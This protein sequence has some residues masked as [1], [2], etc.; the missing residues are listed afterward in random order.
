M[1]NV[2]KEESITVD[3]KTPK[4]F[5]ALIVNVNTTLSWG[6]QGASTQ[7]TLVEDPNNKDEDGKPAP[8][9]INIPPM[10]TPI[11]FPN[12]LTEL[13]P[14]P[15]YD[16]DENSN[17]PIVIEQF[18]LD[19]NDKKIEQTFGPFTPDK[20]LASGFLQ[21]A[22]YS[23]S[24]SGRTY[25][26]VIQS[27]ATVL[28]GVQ[29]VLNEFNGTGLGATLT[30]EVVNLMNVFGHYENLLVGGHYPF[31]ENW[32]N[33]V[34]RGGFG[35]SEV[36]DSGFP[37]LFTRPNGHTVNLFDTIVAM[38]HDPYYSAFGNPIRH[39]N[40]AYELDL[41][42]LKDAIDLKK[43]WYYRISGDVRDLG[44][45]ISE[46]CEI[47]QADWMVELRLPNA[48]SI[49]GNLRLYLRLI[50][51]TFPATPGVNVLVPSKVL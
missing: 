13:V 27:P 21:R 28:D 30:N 10:G 37:L 14:N 44:S 36:D 8:I 18:K 51:R 25:D 19:E 1:V 42:E 49:T 6:S 9:T 4:L 5:G 20:P 34:D 12:Y 40:Y 47:L 7:F 41:T 50:D 46:L 11:L 43:L 35:K 17:V 2:I 29:V 38:T 31:T 32:Y 16:E 39:G 48:N 26:I 23:E 24:L 15:E 22:N 45:L 3:D 33:G